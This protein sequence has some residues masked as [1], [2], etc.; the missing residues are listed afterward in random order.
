MWKHTR[1]EWKGSSGTF[2][3]YLADSGHPGHSELG[4]TVQL[5]GLLAEEEVD[6]VVIALLA[7]DALPHQG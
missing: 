2:P 4:V 1:G 6:L 3:N 7:A 5:Q